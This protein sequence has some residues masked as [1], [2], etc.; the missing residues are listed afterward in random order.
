[1]ALPAIGMLAESW[2][3][4]AVNSLAMGADEVGEFTHEI[5]LQILRLFDIA[6]E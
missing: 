2:C 5:Y 4:N 1:M 6:R 3:R